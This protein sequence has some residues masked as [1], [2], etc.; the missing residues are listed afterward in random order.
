MKEEIQ[1]VAKFPSTS[2]Y[3]IFYAIAL[4]V[5]IGLF[6]TT[7]FFNGVTMMTILNTPKFK[8]KVS[9]FAILMQSILDFASGILIIPLMTLRL[10]NDLICS[11]S[12]VV[13]FVVKKIGFICYVYS[14]T[15]TCV[16]SFERFMGV[17]YPFVHRVKVTKAR[18]LKYVIS[19][20]SAQTL[21]YTFSFINGAK[22]TRPFFVGNILLS[23]AFTLIVYARIFCVRIK[24]NRFPVQQAV[25]ITERNNLTRKGRWMKELKIAKSCFLVVVTT[26]MFSLP[27]I[28]MVSWLSLE[29]VFLDY[30]VRNFCYILTIFNF[31][32]N[33]L[34]YFWRNK[35]LRTEG[36]ARVRNLLNK[37]LPTRSEVQRAENS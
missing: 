13:A 22:I 1:A 8:E 24:N 16:M 26:F 12:C 30:T 28:T 11:P 4:L 5:N 6:F 9:N 37:I 17:L 32:A 31:T 35:A 23:L 20:C 19:V 33:P 10:V 29:N 15:I 7:I 14:M 34:I 3:I 36:L 18:L 2:L 21:F 27:A 25:N